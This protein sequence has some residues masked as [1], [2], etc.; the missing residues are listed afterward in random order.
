M[1]DSNM[2]LRIYLIQNDIHLIFKT[3]MI[4][5]NTYS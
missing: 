4:N 3:T 1:I 5:S 2:N